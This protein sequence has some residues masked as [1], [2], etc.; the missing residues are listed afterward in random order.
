MQPVKSTAFTDGLLRVVGETLI[1]SAIPRLATSGKEEASVV[2]AHHSP[3]LY[4]EPGPGRGADRLTH[5]DL[6]TQCLQGA[7]REVTTAN[8]RLKRMSI[9]ERVKSIPACREVKIVTDLN[10]AITIAASTH[11]TLKNRDLVLALGADLATVCATVPRGQDLSM[12]S[13]HDRV[14]LRAST[15]MRGQIGWAA[16]RAC[17]GRHPRRA[18]PR[19]QA[20]AGEFMVRRAKSMRVF[21]AHVAHVGHRFTGVTT[22][23]ASGSL[24][25]LSS[26]SVT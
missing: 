5:D 16:G 7:G 20:V 26:P 17:T 1:R 25:A 21:E 24:D 9:I 22:G 19:N 12:D 14:D 13:E 4:G 18:R 6:P 15:A 23:A 11:P 8:T 2:S 3:Y 10:S